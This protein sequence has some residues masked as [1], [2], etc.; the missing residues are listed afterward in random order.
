MQRSLVILLASS[1]LVGSV[2]V[3][4]GSVAAQTEPVTSPSGPRVEGMTLRGTDDS[5]EITIRGALGTPAYAVRSR[6]E[7]RVV[8]V[9]LEGATMPTAGLTLTGESSLVARSTTAEIAHGVRLELMTRHPVAYHASVVGGR[10]VVRL[11]RLA[12]GE[13]VPVAGSALAT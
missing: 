1:L 10:L 5:A 11:D 6:D 9:E 7:G 8:V 2:A 13:E 3:P 4:A 12:E